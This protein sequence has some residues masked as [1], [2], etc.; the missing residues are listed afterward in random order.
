MFL[1][2]GF[3]DAFA[4]TVVGCLL[5]GEVRRRTGSAGR[6]DGAERSV[7]PDAVDELARRMV[8]GSQSADSAS[9]LL[10]RYETAV[11]E[12]LKLHVIATYGAPPERKAEVEA[13]LGEARGRVA[14]S[15]MLVKNDLL[16]RDEPTDAS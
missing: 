1:G 9:R 13:A 16:Q 11:Q 4:V 10:D 12:R 15:R 8:P 5:V 3:S 14:A 7:E 2:G 6:D